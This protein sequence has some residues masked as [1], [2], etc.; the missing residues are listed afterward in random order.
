VN[1]WRALLRNGVRAIVKGDAFWEP[2]LTS[3]LTE[4]SS[5]GMHLAIF[6]EPYLQFIL[7]GKKT[8]E[9]RFSERRIAP[10]GHIK[11][12]DVILLKRSGGPVVGLCLA[13]SVWH[14]ELD[15]HSWQE[16]R[17][18]FSQALC[19]QDPEFW[20]RR[21]GAEYATLIRLTKVHSIHPLRISKTDRRGWVILKPEG[22]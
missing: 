22:D 20:R 8:V 4:R 19:A 13:A 7:D 10:Y 12:N 6:V 15:V 17:S 2:Y 11:K 3:V 1:D 21:K 18:E 9:S 16:I 5:I 14:Y